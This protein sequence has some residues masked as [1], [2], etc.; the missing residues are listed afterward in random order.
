MDKYF[1]HRIKKEN[2]TFT[3]GIEVHDT[4]ASAVRSFHGYMKQGYG[5]PNFPNITFVACFV[6]DSDGNIVPEYNAMWQREGIEAENKIFFHHTRLEDGTFSK[7]IDVL[8]NTADAEY[9]FHAEMEYGYENPNHP[10]VEYQSCMVTEMASKIL[11]MHEAWVKT[12]EP[13]SESTEG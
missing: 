2:G 7:N 9:Q 8:D 12:A 6:E 10:N 5:N 4:K 13:S 11:L 3:T 1:M